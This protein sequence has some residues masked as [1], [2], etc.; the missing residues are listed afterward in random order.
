[1]FF[2]LVENLVSFNLAWFWSLLQAHWLMFFMFIALSVF[3][4]PEKWLKFFFILW[5]YLWI[6][7]DFL[8]ISGWIV[9]SA[10]FLFLNYVSR[11][12]L[13]TFAESIP[14]CKDRLPLIFS[15]QFL[16]VLIIYNLILVPLY[17]FG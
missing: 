15:L 3:Y 16:T 2:E 6:F 5:I 12:A 14:W 17:G 11:V 13:M 9:F 10:S 4:K 1:M 8:S 7:S